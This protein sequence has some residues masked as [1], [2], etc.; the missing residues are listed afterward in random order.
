MEA[1]CFT[2]KNAENYLCKN[3]VFKCSKMSD[4]ERHLVTA[5]HQRLT[6]ANDFT[7]ENAI[8]LECI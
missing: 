1:N 8:Y 6:M 3:C 7:P 2:P 5:K 4:W